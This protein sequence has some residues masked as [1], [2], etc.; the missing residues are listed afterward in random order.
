MSS[1]LYV[2]GCVGDALRRWAEGG[3]GVLV[4]TGALLLEALRLSVRRHIAKET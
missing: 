1:I 3:I 2:V 4:L